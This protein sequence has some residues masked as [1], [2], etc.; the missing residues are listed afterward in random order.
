MQRMCGS[1][2]K[3]EKEIDLDGEREREEIE[4]KSR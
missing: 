3:A 2:W 1:K 4:E